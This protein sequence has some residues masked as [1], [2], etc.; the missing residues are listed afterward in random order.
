MDSFRESFEAVCTGLI[1]IRLTSSKSDFDQADEDLEG[2]AAGIGSWIQARLLSYRL[3]QRTGDRYCVLD[4]RQ[5]YHV[6]RITSLHEWQ[7]LDG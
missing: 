3:K 4:R 6:W 1:E 5:S 7:D 2:D